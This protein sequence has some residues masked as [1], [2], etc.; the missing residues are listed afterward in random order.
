[1]DAADRAA[2]VAGWDDYEGEGAWV[3]GGLLR[4]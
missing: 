4:G 3:G 2:V 1:M